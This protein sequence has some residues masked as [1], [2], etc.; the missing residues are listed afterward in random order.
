MR[1]KLSYANVMA[2]LAM[3]IALGGSSYAAITITGKNVK[4]GS[5]TGADIKNNS[6]AGA[7]V[8]R[9]TLKSNDVKNGSLRALDFRSG[10]LTQGSKGDKGDKGDKGETGTVDTSNFYDKSQSDGRY[11]R[12]G[13]E[14]RRRGQA[15]REGLDGLRLGGEDRAGGLRPLLREQRV[16]GEHHSERERRR[17]ALRAGRRLRRR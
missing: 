7:D 6:L 11:L 2:T 4:N 3:F 1:S 10:E 8:R 14:G 12:D 13:R 5:L 17:G 15:R 9:E 16:R